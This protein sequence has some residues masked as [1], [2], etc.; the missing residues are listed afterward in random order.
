MITRPRSETASWLRRG[1]VPVLA[2]LGFALLCYLALDLVQNEGSL[3]ELYKRDVVQGPVLTLLGTLVVWAV[4][5]LVW[6]IVGRLAVGIAVLTVLTAILGFANHVKLTLRLEP[7]LP[8]DL[9][10]VSQVGFLAEM[11]GLAEV[12]VLLAALG[13]V[14]VAIGW[15]SRRYSRSKPRGTRR[16]DPYA[17]RRRVLSRLV[18]GALSVFFLTY[19]GNFNNPGN[20]F[21]DA[22][23]ANGAEWAYWAQGANYLRNGFVG[24]VLYN[25]DTTSME[26]P[27]DYTRASMEQIVRRYVEVADRTNR[28]RR[29]D[30]LDDVNIVHVLSESFTDPTKLSGIRLEEDPIPFTRRLM[31]QTS[32]GTMLAQKVGAGTA[33]MEFEALT[34]M[35]MSQFTPQVDS[36]YQTVVPN[37]STFPSAVQLLKDRGHA[38]IAIH[39]YTT[40]LYRRETVYPVLGMD[41]FISQGEMQTE[42]TIQ[43]NPR[44]SDASAF[45]EVSYQIERSDRP[46]LVN[47]VTMQNHF[48][49]RSVYDE[50]VRVS[51][52][53]GNQKEH[54]A[55]YVRGLR[56]SDAAL[57]DFIAEL[58]RS[59]EKTAVIFYGDHHPPVWPRRIRERN[60]EVGVLSTP[61]FLWAN[62][63]LERLPSERL[64]SPIHFMPML[65]EA[66]G[67]QVP[68]YYALL[69]RLHELVP[70]ME[71]GRY[72]DR[73]KG[74]V[75]ESELG[76]RATQ[77][78][79]DYRMVQYDL[80]VGERYSQEAMF[81]GEQT[82]SGAANASA[83]PS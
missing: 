41:E 33:N 22:Y 20:N 35:S 30:V 2:S 5:V 34:G 8:S 65:Y 46:L 48:P 36:A 47:L 83:G 69:D 74:L 54:V 16:S 19:V 11:A 58:E 31:S 81:S 25:L 32:S 28:A 50:P 62:F 38:A 59:S 7:I 9:A 57:E 71:Q 6:A 75:S 73:G 49:N 64:T 55:G 29:P 23:E 40:Q 63:P 17:W 42:A 51:G 4:L 68:P 78:L 53:T 61:Y 45:E 82:G 76:P 12:L 14:T 66:A 60:G 77:V 13:L 67:A 72:V 37:H 24:G 39:P 44:I 43:D 80:A 52:L 79:R 70:A 21:R 18:A 3:E 56:Y 15:V 27:R 10:Y 26:R 1:A